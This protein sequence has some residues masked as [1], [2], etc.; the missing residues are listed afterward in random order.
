MQF[1]TVSPI[2]CRLLA[3][4]LMALSCLPLPA[5]TV[6]P[7]Q[8]QVLNE[9][10]LP[11]G[12]GRV[13]T[14]PRAGYVF[15][16]A[17]QFRGGGAR[18]AGDWIQG[19]TW[20]ATRKIWVQ[21]EVRWPNAR[22]SMETVGNQRVIKG[23]AL[24]LDHATG[25]FP[26][27]RTD[28]AYQIDRNPNPIAEQVL[29]ISLP[30]EPEPAS[31]PS[32]VPMGPIGVAVNGVPIFN[33]LD[34][35][36]R[37]AVAHE[38]QDRCHGH[39]QGRGVYHYHGPSDCVA[40]TAGNNTLVGYALDGFGIYSGYDTNGREITN[41]DLDA[42]H[43]RTSPVLW[44]GKVVSM[45]HYVMTRE[46]PYTVGCFSGTP[47]RTRV[48]PADSASTT[49]TGGPNM[50]EGRGQPRQAQAPAEAVAACV[51]KTAESACNFTSPTG[52][53]I[54]GSCKHVRGGRGDF[55]CAPVGR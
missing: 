36:G 18:H 34:D 29:T 7:T 1:K 6:Q 15:A 16:C 9:K 51:S 17:T 13:S 19:D 20:D 14:Q 26:V 42:C 48:Q 54:N 46:Y 23:N 31:H 35:A 25:T 30:L 2:T 27:A 53:A 33:A 37:D 32:C 38:V 10:A 41:A 12:D 45:Y 3:V 44:N 40:G 28:P 11:L 8:T 43:G 49:A 22:F 4:C 55:A 39:P 47:V 21:G 5:Q 50:G 24:P 52:Q